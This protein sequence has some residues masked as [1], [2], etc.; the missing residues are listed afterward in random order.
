[1][2]WI[3]G[4]TSEGRALACF[5]EKQGLEITVSVATE[6]G[7]QLLDGTFHGS[8]RQ[9]RMDE[10]QMRAA[11]LE[12]GA[13][14]VIDAT[15]P[16]ASQAT[17]H[18]RQA[19]ENEKIPYLRLVRDSVC[20]GGGQDCPERGKN[21][22]DSGRNRPIYV[23]SA[24]EAARWLAST[25]G[26]IMVTTGSKELSVFC[27]ELEP[28][29]LVARVLPSEASIRT[30]EACGILPARR[31][32]MQGPFSQAVNAALLEQFQCRYLVTKESGAAGGFAEKL[33]A[34][35]QMGVQA[36]VIRRPSVETGMTFPEICGYLTEKFGISGDRSQAEAPP[37]SN[38]EF[39][40]G[41][42][43]LPGS[44]SLPDSRFG[45]EYLPVIIAGIGMGTAETMTKEVET[46]IRR[47]D[48]LIGGSRM[49][50][51]YEETGKELFASYRPEEIR[52]FILEHYRPGT[53]IVVLMSGDVG[54]YSGAK[55][56]QEVLQTRVEESSAGAP[57]T[58]GSGQ[59]P[60]S[61]S[62]A[63]PALSVRL[64]PGISSPV[65]LAAR[66][67][68]SWQDMVLCSIHGR[69]QNVLGKIRKNPRVFVLA[70]NGSEISALCG[71][72]VW[73]GLGQIETVV[74]EHLSYPEE[75]IWRGTA[76]EAEKESFAP[77]CCA[78][79]FHPE[80][81]KTPVFAG[82]PDEQFLRGKVPMTK[83]EIRTLS[84]SKL[85]LCADSI[86]YDIGAGTGS[87]S[88]QAALTAEDGMVYAIEKKEEAARLIEQ[89]CEHFGVTNVTVV[90]GLA[91][92]AM[93]G[94]PVPTH[95]FI[96]GSSGRLVDM[97]AQLF[98]QNPEMR[99]V[100]NAI[101]LET[102]GELTALSKQYETELVMVT[103]ARA[104]PVGNYQLL[105]GQNP[106]MIGT[107]KGRNHGI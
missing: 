42:E 80:A 7:E 76:L 99:I 1:M 44:E 90:R 48:I 34:C 35:A 69:N 56:L 92:E 15:H 103:A 16:Y 25:A 62:A 64:C 38:P 23:E 3:F 63:F 104:N 65:Y 47:A 102:I 106:V 58:K 37:D 107:V 4:G 22:G 9:G 5:C 46:A 36:V 70:G 43:S 21:H 8:V 81:E 33:A 101:S 51:P 75:R 100:I 6:Y 83:E 31:I 91:P 24:R 98:A 105:T 17:A 11:F 57:G 12:S 97:V 71:Q 2:I 78:V 27:E 60:V 59:V 84:L 39:R 73:A 49:L 93:Q 68:I 45:T 26:N 54:F 61:E 20:G 29:R 19:C 88:I 13:E 72:L 66:L 10:A 28:S 89:N 40:P 50:K 52:Q 14:L 74:G 77:L 32:A 86:V 41:M 79:F 67:G 55:R 53:R 95:A 30:C 18:I 96:G 82:I 94:L 87:V 85:R